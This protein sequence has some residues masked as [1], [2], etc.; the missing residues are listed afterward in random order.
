L[1]GTSIHGV[2]HAGSKPA[3]FESAYWPVATRWWDAATQPGVLIALLI[4]LPV[5]AWYA[6]A[7]TIALRARKMGKLLLVAAIIFVSC[8]AI[9][10]IFTHRFE[11]RVG[12]LVA[13]HRAVP[14]WNVLVFMSLRDHGVPT[15]QAA[16]Q[17]V[18]EESP[19]LAATSA[20]ERAAA[21]I[22][23]AQ[24]RWDRLV[25]AA[26]ADAQPQRRAA[27]RLAA[28]RV[29]WDGWVSVWQPRYLGMI[30]P[31]IAIAACALL[32]RLPTRPLRYTAIALF[33]ALNLTQ[34]IARITARTEPPADRIAA[35]VA[36]SQDIRAGQPTGTDTRTW[37]DGI[38]GFAVGDRMSNADAQLRYYLAQ[39][40]GQH[41]TPR[42]FRDTPYPVSGALWKPWD[43][44]LLY[45][46]SPRD[47]AHDLEA[48]PHI[49]RAVIWDGGIGNEE[50][51]R[52]L[53]PA[54]R[55]AGEQTF[56]YRLHWTWSEF[57]QY[58]RREF[59]RASREAQK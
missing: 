3:T 5:I 49:R 47:I 50:I 55:L 9:Y 1:L 10:G 13:D 32:L 48:S 30:W 46:R 27:E 6:A 2:L 22:A 57:R 59:V 43:L 31:A 41:V 29:V 8:F 23:A 44:R 35:D 19:N 11:R 53:G 28:E 37:L 26:A 52:Q 56:K 17:E 40:S 39:A 36:A 45:N 38:M 14:S 20:E 54:W 18:R 42:D 58:R 25:R 24:R 51:T 12:Q 21:R 33:I 34:A 4:L 15:T 7:P 16:I